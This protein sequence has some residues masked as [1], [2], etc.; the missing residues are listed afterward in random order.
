MAFPSTMIVGFFIIPSRCRGTLFF[1]PYERS[2]PNAKWTVP[3]TF[4]SSR[5]FPQT[6]ALGFVPI[7]ISAI[8]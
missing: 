8:L 6:F 5:I 2:F 7:P 3:N 4:S 1:P